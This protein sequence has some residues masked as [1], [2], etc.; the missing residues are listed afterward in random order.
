MFSYRFMKLNGLNNAQRIFYRNY[1]DD[2]FVLFESAKHLPKFHAYLN[3]Y[4]PNMSFSFEQEV[5]GKL[6]FLNIHVSP[7]Q[8]DL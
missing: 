4:H 6:S 8:Q 2:I 7:Q 1:V 5:S 3:T